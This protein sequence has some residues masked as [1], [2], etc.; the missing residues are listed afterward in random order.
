M[1]IDYQ[2]DDHRRLITVTVTEPFSFD[3]LLNQTDRQWA[4]ET[5]EYAVLYDSRATV[6]L[7]PPSELHDLLTRTQVVGGGRKRGPVGVAIPPRA[8]MFNSGQQLAT[9]GGPGR[10]IEILMNVEQISAWIGRQAPR[11]KSTGQ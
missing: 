10:D 1:P 9:L 11:R 8:E 2:R 3:E 6:H 5:W 7:Y 4:E